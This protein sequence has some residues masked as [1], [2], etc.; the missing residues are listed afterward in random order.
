MT[1][2]HALPGEL[3]PNAF[4][5]AEATRAGVGRGRLR[6]RDLAAPY[7]GTRIAMG[8]PLTVEA[9]ARLVLRRLGDRVFVSHRSAAVI[10]R[11]QLETP[12]HEPL[13]V[14]VVAPHRAPHATGISG[15]SLRLTTCDVTE[16]SGLP[17]TTPIRTWLD[18]AA[19]GSSTEELVVAGDRITNSRAPLATL[20]ALCRAVDGYRGRGIRHLHEAL[21]LIS[22]R[23][24]SS[25]ETRVRTAIL[26]QGL[27]RPVLQ[28]PI[29]GGD[30]SLIGIADFAFPEYRVLLEYEGDHHRTERPQW[31]RDLARFNRYQQ[32]GWI[33]L[34]IDAGQ[35]ATIATALDTLEDVLRRRGWR[36]AT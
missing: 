2:R 8:V 29:H 23:S 1:A 18:L 34:R 33:A 9:R 3:D 14:S 35:Y 31:T 32:Q 7:N 10:W 28:L 25:R 24:D 4:T 21:P 26:A 30:G 11:F 17:V 13:H 5:I 15:H 12:A 16:R 19:S 27:P 22:D 36:P 20:D 6:G